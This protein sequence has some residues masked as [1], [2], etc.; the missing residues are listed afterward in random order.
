MWG[1]QADEVLGPV[2]W[3]CTR[4]WPNRG[5][6]PPACQLYRGREVQPGNFPFPWP[7]PQ[8]PGESATPR[9]LQSPLWDLSGPGLGLGE[10]PRSTCLGPWLWGA[11]QVPGGR[12]G[13]EGCTGPAST[14]CCQKCFSM[15]LM[16]E[17]SPVSRFANFGVLRGQRASRTCPGGTRQEVGPR[18][19]QSSTGPL[20][21]ATLKNTS[22][23][24]KWLS[25]WQPQAL[26]SKHRVLLG[27]GPVGKVLHNPQTDFLLESLEPDRPG[28]PLALVW[29]WCK[30]L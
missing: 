16:M 23:E 4:T 10:M 6:F 27:R 26:N 1:A 25:R 11:V 14:M 13:P 28:S 15:G 17:T 20:H 12:W 2:L 5:G 7:T 18:V 21:H 19:C 3:L 24:R 30:M 22:S 29:T 9:R 8:P